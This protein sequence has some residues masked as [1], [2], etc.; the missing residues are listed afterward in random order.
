MPDITA[1]LQKWSDGDQRSFEELIAAVY[2]ELRLLARRHLSREP[3][4][5][6]LQPTA[7][8]HETF[9]RLVG[10]NRTQ[11]AGRAHF[12]GAAAR[13]MRRVLVDEARRRKSLKRGGGIE[14]DELE[15]ALPVTVDANIDLLDLDRALQEFEAMDPERARLIEL[16]F[17]AGLSIEETA[18]VLGVSAA[19]ANRDW[20]LV[21]AWLH[22]RLCH[23]ASS[24]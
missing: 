10:L 23:S 16:R 18:T 20:V 21:R 8:V 9:L 13:V 12:F 2:G 14:P 19:T 22:K 24:T 15:R 17:F 11:W 3:A 5:L 4:A 1:L 6:T 7:L